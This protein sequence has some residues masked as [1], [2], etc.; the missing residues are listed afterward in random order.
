MV[1]SAEL[2]RCRSV[3]GCGVGHQVHDRPREL[4]GGDVSQGH[5][6]E[7]EPLR[8]A[9]GDPDLLQ[10]GCGTDV[11]QVLGPAAPDVGQLP[12]QR[13]DDVGDADAR[14]L[15]G[16]TVAAVRASLAAEQPAPTQLTEDALEVLVG[17]PLGSGELL[18]GARRLGG[19]ELGHGAQGVV[20]PGG[21]SHPRAPVVPTGPPP[22][23][24]RVA[25]AP[26]PDGVDFTAT[27]R[28]ARR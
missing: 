4:T 20:Y 27:A 1:D 14:G 3:P 22:A 2:S 10:W 6:L 24:S 21:E 9:Q 12:V 17:N 5:A 15:T 19:G 7:D 8:R 13:A 18:D 23:R 25:R 26:C 16:E 28:R 11:L